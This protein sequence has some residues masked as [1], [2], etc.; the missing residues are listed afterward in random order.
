[1]L[2]DT[3][4]HTPIKKMF[5]QADCYGVGFDEERAAR[6]PVRLG[7]IG[8]GGIAVSKY[9]PSVK[10]L[11]T[12]WE[13]VEVVAFVHTDERCGRMI[14][15][16]WGGCW[17][18]DY[19][20]MLAEE[21]LDGVLVLSPSDL[22]AE[23]A[24][25]CIEAGLPVLVEKPFALSLA[26]G[27][28]VCRAAETQGVPLLSVANKRFSPP[29][30]RAMRFVREGPV[31]DPAMFAGKFNLGYDYAILMLEG[32]TIHVFD[33]ARFFMGDVARLSA[34]GVNKYGRHAGKYPFDNAMISLEYASGSVGQIYTTPSA[35]SLKPWERVE[36]YGNNAWLTVEDQYELILYDSEEGPT[37]SWRPVIPNTLILDE[38]FGGYMGL[39]EHFL[40]VIRGHE[41]PLVT[42]WD[43]HRA[44]ELNVATLLSLHRGGPVSLPLD[45]AA[46]DAERAEVV[47]Y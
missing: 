44:Y 24:L 15:K 11:Q 41:T 40:E 26:D 33:L 17:Y 3:Y 10:R 37:K 29:Y 27:E 19:E 14:E 45:P 38:E 21:K 23:H 4:G 39:V 16:T 30:R 9:F 34:I 6:R 13:P 12:V 18:K 1:M 2:E 35:L 5:D 22:H 36:V 42:G 47:A 7:F 46:A 28:R 43:G 31:N 8:A 32:G 25:A 20:R